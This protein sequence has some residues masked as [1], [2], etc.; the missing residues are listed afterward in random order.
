LAQACINQTNAEFLVNGYFNCEEPL[1]IGDYLYTDC[2]LETGLPNGYYWYDANTVYQI[3]DESSAGQIETI[4]GCDNTCL[5]Y[6][7]ENNTEITI[8]VS[9]YDCSGGQQ[10]Y[11]NLPSGN[12][13][14][15]CANTFF[16][17]INPGGGT[18]FTVGPCS[19]TTTTSTTTEGEA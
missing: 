4:P 1:A 2:T 12:Q 10:T 6:R 19:T 5:E 16:G 15:F 9:W 17:P 14:T 13:T 8:S 18:L 7:V 11:I 3:T